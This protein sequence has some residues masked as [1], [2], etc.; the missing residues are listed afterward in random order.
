M[1]GSTDDSYLLSV[2]SLIVDANNQPVYKNGLNVAADPVNTFSGV[3]SQTNQGVITYI[4]GGLM[5][6]VTNT[7]IP[8][9]GVEFT[10]YTN[11]IVY[12]PIQDGVP[13]SWQKTIFNF[14]KGVGMWITLVY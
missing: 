11:E 8:N 5:D 10:T 2:S 13:T 4:I 7:L 3:I 6:I 12:G 9:T 14:L 1:T